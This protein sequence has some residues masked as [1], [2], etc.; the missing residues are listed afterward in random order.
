MLVEK[1]WLN[2]FIENFTTFLKNVETFSNARADGKKRGCLDG[3]WWAGN[4]H[5]YPPS[6]S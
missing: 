4:L 3:F 6:G 1:C 5:P 2:I